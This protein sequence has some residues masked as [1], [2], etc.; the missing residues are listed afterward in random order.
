MNVLGI[1][2]VDPVFLQPRGFSARGSFAQLISTVKMGTGVVSGWTFCDT[3]TDF[4]TISCVSMLYKRLTTGRFLPWTCLVTLYV[5]V[6]W[7]KQPFCVLDRLANF[8]VRG[9]AM[10]G[11]RLSWL[12]LRSFC[13]CTCRTVVA[14]RRNKLRRSRRC[15][16]SLAK[17]RIWARW[18]SSSAAISTLS[19]SWNLTM[20]TFKD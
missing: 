9:K 8:A 14:M 19:S 1:V 4:C 18:T 5:V 6:I 11:S 10:K 13:P 17:V 12:V 16:T 7:V 3:S 20:R 15:G 2:D